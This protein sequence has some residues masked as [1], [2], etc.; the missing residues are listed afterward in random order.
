MPAHIHRHDLKP[1]ILLTTTNDYGT[2]TRA[3]NPL[4]HGPRPCGSTNKIN[5]LGQSL[6]LAFLFLIPL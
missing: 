1:L 4:V 3:H 5:N 6:R 2:L